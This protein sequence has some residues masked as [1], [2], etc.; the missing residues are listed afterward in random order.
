ME[1]IPKVKK[2]LMGFLKDSKP[3]TLI[4]IL[5]LCSDSYYNSNANLITDEEYDRIREHLEEIDPK[6]KSVQQLLA[7]LNL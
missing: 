1:H 2:S 7:E 4:S 5:K 3:K 6:N